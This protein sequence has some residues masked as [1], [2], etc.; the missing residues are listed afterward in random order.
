M[1]EVGAPGGRDRRQ[2]LLTAPL[3]RATPG[4]APEHRRAAR[5][6]CGLRVAVVPYHDKDKLAE[7][8]VVELTENFA[9][10]TNGAAPRSG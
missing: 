1:F 8:L 5:D 10:E 9:K 2:P 3:W 7:R 4:A 6:R